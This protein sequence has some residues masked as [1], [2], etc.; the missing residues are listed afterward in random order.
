[1]IIIMHLIQY[2]EKSNKKGAVWKD[3]LRQYFSIFDTIIL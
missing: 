2:N 1:M 3:I